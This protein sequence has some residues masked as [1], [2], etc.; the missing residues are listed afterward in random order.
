MHTQCE[1]SLEGRMGG[2]RVLF[3]IDSK[4]KGRRDVLLVSETELCHSASGPFLI[5]G[6]LSTSDSWRQDASY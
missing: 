6:S 5:A 1:A 3:T 2:R 4:P